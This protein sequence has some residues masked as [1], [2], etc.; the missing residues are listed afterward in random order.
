[1]TGAIDFSVCDF[2]DEN[3]WF[4]TYYDFCDN[5]KQIKELFGTLTRQQKR[6]YQWYVYANIHMNET[7]KNRIW[8]YLNDYD[9]G[10]ELMKAKRFYREK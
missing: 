7:F 4:F 8:D 10:E 5:R 1:M 6:F 3:M 9:R 2:I